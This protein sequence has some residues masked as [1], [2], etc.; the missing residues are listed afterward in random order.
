MAIAMTT[1]V[2][3]APETNFTSPTYTIAVDT[4]PD[5]N[6]KQYY[7]SA[8]GGTQVGVTT[9]SASSPFTLT[10]WKPKIAKLLPKIGLNG[11]YGSIPKNE[12]KFIVRKGCTPA[13]GQPAELMICEV[14]MAI[15]A[16]AETYDSANVRACMS[17]AIGALTQQSAGLGDTLV[18]NAF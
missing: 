8:V 18:S 3:G 6:G 10:W 15:P 5:V 16:G 1:P 13:A 12:Y 11:Q 7:V 4:A 2:T 9:H 14:R 17:L